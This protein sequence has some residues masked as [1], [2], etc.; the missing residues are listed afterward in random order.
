MASVNNPIDVVAS[1]GRR[2]YR[3]ATELL[4]NDP[5]VDML[6]V[7]CA[8]PTFAGMTQTEHAAGTL[9]GVRSAGIDKPVVGVW[10]SAEVGKPGKDLLEM[11]RIPCYDDPAL[12][13]L[14]M[15]KTAEY[16]YYLQRER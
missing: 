14:C 4:L 8:V 15:S 9:E 11:N 2:E 7:V 16:A 6:L 3:V 5:N 1:G 13:A 10:L 12:A